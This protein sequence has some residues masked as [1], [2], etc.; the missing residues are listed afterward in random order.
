MSVISFFKTEQPSDDEFRIEG[1]KND[2]SS[3]S[4]K[5]LPDWEKYIFIPGHSN[6]K[7]T[8]REFLLG[9][10][11]C[12]QMISGLIAPG[13]TGKT[14]QRYLAYVAVATDRGDLIG[15]H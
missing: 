5:A 7:P 13:A 10:V 3:D 9:T 2:F 12:R 15:M 11:F 1:E 4:E 8:P 6:E 14:A